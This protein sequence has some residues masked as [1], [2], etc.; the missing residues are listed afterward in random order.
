MGPNH[1]LVVKWLS[2]VPKGNEHLGQQL[3]C[4]AEVLSVQRHLQRILKGWSFP[5]WD[6]DIL[7]SSLLQLR[8]SWLFPGHPHTGPSP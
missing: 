3:H 1:V 6:Q 2:S 8:R 7:S 5:G 4:E